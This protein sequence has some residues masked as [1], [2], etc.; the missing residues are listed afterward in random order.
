MT[1][2]NSIE[3]L[4]T[5][6]SINTFKALSWKTYSTSTYG[7]STISFNKL[8]NSSSKPS[9]SSINYKGDRL[10]DNGTSRPS[11]YDIKGEIFSL[12]IRSLRKQDS[13]SKILED[14]DRFRNLKYNWDGNEAEE[15]TDV[16]IKVAKQVVNEL[17]HNG[18]SI[19][20][21]VPMRDGGVQ[22]DINGSLYDK[23][24]EIHPNGTI[25]LIIY[26]KTADVVDDKLISAVDVVKTIKQYL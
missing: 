18:I 13:Y 22:V 1:K 3:R 24:I 19:D 7:T 14:I 4:G 9:V 6:E 26:N 20:I 23:E 12:F 5:T 17:A 15:T 21:C 2:E 11:S 10:Y 25:N 16:A 8:L